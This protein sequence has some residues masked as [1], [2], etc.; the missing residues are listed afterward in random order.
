MTR[1]KENRKVAQRL[2]RE[3]SD[4]LD[5]VNLALAERL[6]QLRE[7]DEVTD[8]FASTVVGPPAEDGR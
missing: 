8:P 1:A 7:E 2:T 5:R 6:Q 4:V 3:A